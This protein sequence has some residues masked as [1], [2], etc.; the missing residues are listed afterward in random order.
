MTRN[1]WI[2][3]ALGVWLAMAAFVLSHATRTGIIEDLIAGLTVALA[4]LWA[5]RAYKPSVSLVA[6]WTVVLS[7]LWVVAAPFALGYERNS[8]AVANDVVV[9]LAILALGIVNVTTKDR[10]RLQV[11]PDGHDGIVLNG[12]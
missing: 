6:S 11:R 5:A 12:R 4:A 9:G 3:V 1:S 10:R 2:N 8:G 7:G